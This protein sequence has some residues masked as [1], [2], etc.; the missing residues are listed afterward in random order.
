MEQI[1]SRY[2]AN[3]KNRY[4]WQ[5]KN[6]NATELTKQ[7]AKEVEDY[8]AQNPEAPK[9]VTYLTIGAKFGIN[10]DSSA[11]RILRIAR[12]ISVRPPSRRTKSPS[13]AT[14]GSVTMT[15]EQFQKFLSEREAAKNEYGIELLP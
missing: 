1:T 13:K 8:L 3:G 7:Y 9:E 11:H 14:K 12:G 4:Q 6:G 15:R 5:D 2:Q 10:N